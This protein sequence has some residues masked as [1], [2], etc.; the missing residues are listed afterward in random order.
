MPTD[1]PPNSLEHGLQQ[2]R[3]DLVTRYG[4]VL[5]HNQLREVLGYRTV[6][7]FQRAVS[8]GRIGVRVFNVPGRR[9]KFALSADVADWL[10]KAKTQADKGEG[11]EMN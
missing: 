6:S 11:G 1:V 8:L 4:V 7:A 2:L 9:G 10:W 5:D 3:A